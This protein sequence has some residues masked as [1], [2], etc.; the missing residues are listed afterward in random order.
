MDVFRQEREELT[1]LSKTLPSANLGQLVK[2]LNVIYKQ[3]EQEEFSGLQKQLIGISLDMDL[4]K[5]NRMVEVLTSVYKE[6]EQEELEQRQRAK[7][8]FEIRR[9]L[10]QEERNRE[11]LR[12]DKLYGP[13]IDKPY[14]LVNMLLPIFLKNG[15]RYDMG[16]DN[17]HH[18]IVYYPRGRVPTLS[19]SVFAL[20]EM[21]KSG[22]IYGPK[23]DL[24][25]ISVLYRLFGK[26]AGSEGSQPLMEYP[27]Q[28]EVKKVLT[29]I[30][31]QPDFDIMGFSEI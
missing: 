9:G 2:I 13:Y 14:Q 1:S 3:R 27:T 6:R 20:P 26:R 31:T 19:E 25:K 10:E 29:A 21:G 30:V 15:F 22:A 16:N 28:E 24:T 23:P 18:G 12:R 17:L 8:E 7:E 5:L 11:Q 4:D